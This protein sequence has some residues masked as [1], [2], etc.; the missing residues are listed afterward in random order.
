MIRMIIKDK[1]ALLKI[2]VYLTAHMN[3]RG[4]DVVLVLRVPHD[5][6]LRKH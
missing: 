2:N 1:L 4:T 6:W 3:N 5:L